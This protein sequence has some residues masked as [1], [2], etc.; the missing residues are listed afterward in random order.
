MN[1]R[2]L[3]LSLSLSL[4]GASG[5]ALAQQAPEA[6]R[7]CHHGARGERGDRPAPQA[8]SVSGP[9]ARYVVGPGGHVRGFTLRD[10][11]LV[12]T[13]GGDALAQRVAVGTTVAVDGLRAPNGNTI[14]RASVRLPDGTELV[15]APQGR[16]GPGGGHGWHRGRGAHRQEGQQGQAQGDRR[17][18]WQ[19]RMASLTP[20]STT[21][22]VQQVVGGRRG[23]RMLLLSDN[24]TVVLARGMG[25]SL[26]ERTI[27][28]GE[29]VTV[30]GRGGAYPQGRSILADS[31]RLADGT[32][33]TPAP[34]PQR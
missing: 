18:R 33:I 2:T 32:V 12:M 5:A 10:G 15:A 4:L 27:R 21:A 34:A 6:P 28:P 1:V 3:A 11:T 16:G 30:Q 8:A 26:G 24:T 22:Q 19:E 14:F 13:R 23:A 20:Q 25:R 29:T 9:I 17:A 31:L 7:E